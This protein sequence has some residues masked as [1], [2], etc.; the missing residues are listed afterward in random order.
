MYDVTNRKSYESIETWI[1]RA[2]Y[3]FK[4][5]TPICIVGN[6]TDCIDERVVDYFEAQV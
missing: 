4:A 3:Y 5:N 1:E 2:K 6:K